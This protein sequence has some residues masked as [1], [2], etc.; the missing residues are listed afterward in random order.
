MIADLRVFARNLDGDGRAVMF[1]E[2]S[3]D[4]DKPSVMILPLRTPVSWQESPVVRTLED[5]YDAMFRQLDMLF[6]SGYSLG[7]AMAV[8]EYDHSLVVPARRV[9]F[10]NHDKACEVSSACGL[11]CPGCELTDTFAIIQLAEGRYRL[12]QVGLEYTT[13]DPDA[14]T[15]MSTGFRGKATL[16][17]QCHDARCSP[18]M[19]KWERAQY[20]AS[21][22]V[23]TGMTRGV[24]CAG[25][26]AYRMK[27]ANAPLPRTSEW[28]ESR[29]L[30]AII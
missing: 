29:L 26:P 17:T 7:G 23:N 2:A 1:L 24:V 11:P 6:F 18:E 8:A 16:Y 28:I 21:V 13:A 30:P 4:L 27:L 3:V 14:V 25:T 15:Y 22:T 9:W 10:G 19:G 12:R 5:D 20:P